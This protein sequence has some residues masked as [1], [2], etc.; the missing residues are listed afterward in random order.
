MRVPLLADLEPEE[1]Q[2]LAD[3]MVPQI[4]HAGDVV[5][6]EGAGGDGFF[7]VESGEASVNVQGEKRGAIGPFDCFGEVA[8]LMGSEMNRTATKKKRE[9]LKKD[10]EK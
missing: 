10:S 8:L 6:A 7:V 4:F 1:F 5:T 9:R 2:L 3:A